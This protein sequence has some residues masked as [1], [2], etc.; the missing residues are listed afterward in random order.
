MLDSIIALSAGDMAALLLGGL[1][2][3]VLH[4]FGKVFE[5]RNT[6][7]SITLKSYFIDHY[8]ETVI[9]SGLLFMAIGMMID[10]GQASWWMAAILGYN[11][12]SLA[13]KFR[14]RAAGVR[15]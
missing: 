14:Q 2:G 3:L 10:S 11:V 9:S 4:Y 8:Q 5:L 7:R 15:L 6:D 12:D 13:N 1:L